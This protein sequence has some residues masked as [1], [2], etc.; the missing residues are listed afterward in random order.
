MSKQVEVQLRKSWSVAVTHSTTNSN[1]VLQQGA[2]RSS[3][4][5]RVSLG[6]PTGT[7]LVGVQHADDPSEHLQSAAPHVRHSNGFAHRVQVA[8][9]ERRGQRR[10]SAATVSTRE[11]GHLSVSDGSPNFCNKNCRMNSGKLTSSAGLCGYSLPT[12]RPLHT[13]VAHAVEHSPSHA[14]R[15]SRK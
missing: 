11:R 13:L 2:G 4:V 14:Y 15:S 9:R 12:L 10:H 5:Q 8:A 7:V 3:R 6:W 1:M